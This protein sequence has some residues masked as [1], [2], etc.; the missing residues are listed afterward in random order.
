MLK[1]KLEYEEIFADIVADPD[2]RTPALEIINAFNKEDIINQKFL[3]EKQ[4]L[5]QIKT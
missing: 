5:S 3:K 2:L 4:R 1:V